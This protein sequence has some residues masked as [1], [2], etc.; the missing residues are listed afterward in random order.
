MVMATEKLDLGLDSRTIVVTGAAQGIGRAV[1]GWIAGLGARVVLADVQ[2]CAA[3]A[4]EVGLGAR[5]LRLDLTDPS[6]ID[7]LLA[8]VTATGP[9]YGVVNCAGL[10][11][12][13]PL[14]TS[15]PEEIEKQTAVNQWGVFHLARAAMAAMQAQGRGGRIV[16]YTSQGAFTGG[17]HGSIP[18]AMNK[19]AVTALVKSLARIGAPDGITVNAVAPGAIDTAMFRGGLSQADVDE[20]QKMIPMGRIGDP[21]DVAGPTAFLLSAWAGY[22]TGTTM[23]VNGG[24]LML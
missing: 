12:R 22:V 7:A 17:F 16:L 23:H 1:A 13:R 19:A 3:A 9:L 11:L 5:A 15:T 8:D 18:Y 14:A 21:E 10:L 6:S 20:F 2:D 24:Q 4:E